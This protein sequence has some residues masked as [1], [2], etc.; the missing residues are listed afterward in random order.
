MTVGDVKWSWDRFAAGSSFRGELLN[1]I[2]EIG[3]VDSVSFP[4]DRTITVKLAYPYAQILDVVAYYPYFNV[5][6]VEAENQFDPKNTMRGSGPFRLREYVP[7]VH[8]VYDK[9]PDWYAKD[10]PFLDGMEK[11]II[12]DYSAALAQFEA[13]ALWTYAV[14]GQDILR[15]KQDHTQLVLQRGPAANNPSIQR[16]G[17]SHPGAN[18]GR[19]RLPMP[20]ADAGFDPWPEDEHVLAE[21]MAWP[22]GPVQR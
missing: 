19:G 7:S 4:D 2:S 11:L 5:M 6:P 10:R 3:M 20:N 12:A 15:L 22:P 13:K 8:Y 1:S 18:R 17:E 16:R 21:P 14:K 9:N